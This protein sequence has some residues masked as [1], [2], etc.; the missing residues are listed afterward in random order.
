METAAS[1]V[2]FLAELVRFY[3]RQG[4]IVERVLTDNGT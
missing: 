1:A 4:I 3:A 2:A